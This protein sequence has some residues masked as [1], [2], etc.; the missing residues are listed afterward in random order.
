MLPSLSALIALQS[1]D[2][3]AEASR[4]RLAELP[5]AEQAIDASIA[6]ATGEV[7]AAR[8]GLKESQTARRALEKDVA[9]VDARL[10][11]F[12][13]HKAVVK[14]NQEY[15]AL[16]HEIATAKSEKD[17]IEER[18]LVLMEDADR[19]AADLNAADT[20]LAAARH[21]G[22]QRRAALLSERAALDAELVRL[23]SA[24]RRPAGEDRAACPRDLRTVAQG[25][26]RCGGRADGRRDLL[27]LSR[28]PAP[29]RHPDDSTQR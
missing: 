20:R 17:G 2:G 26:P 23:V 8:A 24:A 14:T 10:S 6:A 5:K 3:A 7:E 13:D 22:D 27:G 29:A 25:P 1:I 15:T 4:R 28:P 12:D 18:I 21:D 9:A 11:R 16:L 19:L